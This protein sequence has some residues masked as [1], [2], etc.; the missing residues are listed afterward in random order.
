MAEA[1]IFDVF[2]LGNMEPVLYRREWGDQ[3][4]TKEDVAEWAGEEGVE[5]AILQTGWD[6]IALLVP[7]EWELNTVW[8]FPKKVLFFEAATSF[9]VVESEGAELLGKNLDDF[10]LEF[11][12]SLTAVQLGAR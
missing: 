8:H 10:G 12:P 3:Q 4:Y 7:G 9:Y 1:R 11:P 6:E 2:G 5:F